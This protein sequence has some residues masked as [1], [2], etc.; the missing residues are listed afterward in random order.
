[1][2]SDL[3]YRLRALLRRKAVEGELDDELRFHFERQVEK[4]VAA[5]MARAEAER[6]AR[7]EFGGVESIKEECREARGVSV[8][9]TTAQ[10]VRYAVRTLRKSPAFTVIAAVTLALG[11]GAN[12]AIFSVIEAV[13]LRA[14]PYKDPGR[15]V[16]F[17]GDARSGPLSGIDSSVTYADFEAWKSQSR[18]F[19]DVAAY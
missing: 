2:W 17:E 5:G 10:D 9:E 1:V 7:M 15:L 16:R 4:Y 8:I 6:R 11:I 19:E 13:I 12:T 3:L 14:L 18:A